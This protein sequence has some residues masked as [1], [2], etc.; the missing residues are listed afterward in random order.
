MY[1]A[2]WAWIVCV[3]VTVVVSLMTKPRP[4]AELEGLVMGVSAIPTAEPCH[5][6]Q[7]PIFWGGLVAAVFVVL[8]VVLW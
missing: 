1:R 2:L 8:N 6:Y 4:T 7:E 5:W 3:G